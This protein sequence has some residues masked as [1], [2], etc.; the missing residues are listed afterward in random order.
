MATKQASGR[1]QDKVAIVFGG[2]Y[3]I[4]EG[5]VKVL[6]REGAKVVMTGRKEDKGAEA[7]KNMLGAIY[8]QADIA[9]LQS[10]NRV[11]KET[12]E[13]FGVINIIVCNAGIYPSMKV[14]NLTEDHITSVIDVNLK[15]TIIATKACLPYLKE[16]AKAN[17][18][19]R[20]IFISSITGEHTGCPSIGVYA[21]TKAGQL[22]FMR[23]AA[24]ELAKDRITVN[25]V[26]P[27]N[28]PTDSLLALLKSPKM[29]DGDCRDSCVAAVPLGRLGTPEDIGNAVSFLASDEANYI[30]GQTIVVDG[31]QTLVEF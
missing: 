12:H 10:C 4:G 27:G 19:A 31:G 17:G 3:G 16:C 5:I 23:T 29:S 7:E 24:V 22:G 21:A 13:R 9:D 26:L 11:A 20:V 14:E 6:Q 18:G 1:L 15:G 25:A 2:T 8:M 30:T 28:V